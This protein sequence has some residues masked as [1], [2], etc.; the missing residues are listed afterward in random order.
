MRLAWDASAFSKP[1]WTKAEQATSSSTPSIET[2]NFPGVGHELLALAGPSSPSLIEEAAVGTTAAV[3][4]K[5]TVEGTDA[6]GEIRRH[7]ILVDKS[8]DRLLDGEIGLSVEGRQE[9]RGGPSKRRCEPRGRRLHALSTDLSRLRRA[10]TGQGL[11]DSPHPDR[12]GRRG[13][14]AI[15]VGC[16]VG[17]AIRASPSPSRRCKR[18]ARTATP[19]LTELTARLGSMMPYRQ[20]ASVMAEFLPLEAT[21]SHATVRK[22]TIRTGERLDRQAA[23][24]ER[25]AASQIKDRRQLELE[26]PGDRRREFVISVDTA[27]VRSADPKSARNFELVVA[28]CGRGG[29]GEVGGRYFVTASTDQYAL[30]GRTLHALGQEGYRGFGDVAVISDGAELLKRLPRAMPKPTAHIIDWF[31]IAM[32]VQ[33]R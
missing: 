1:R 32:K 18:S 9:D 10:P 22:R 27:H 8:W 12:L 20:A 15:P 14:F 7:E 17:I 30:R 19:E 28:R 4:W 2:G 6:F 24:E 25:S 16:C 13:R 23:E 3:E 31:H 33:P 5:I 11:H 26:L 21:E 29:R